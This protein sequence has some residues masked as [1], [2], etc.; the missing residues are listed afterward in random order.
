MGMSRSNQQ[1][2]REL[3]GIAS[4]ADEAAHVIGRVAL[5]LPGDQAL[6]L[7]YALGL[8][9]EG[10]DKARALADRVKAGEVVAT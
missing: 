7:M 2:R 10:I 3:R 1:L 6:A 8:I 4:R 5:T 9:Y